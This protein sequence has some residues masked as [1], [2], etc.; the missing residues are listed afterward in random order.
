MLC[1]NVSA[2]DF[3]QTRSHQL[4]YRVHQGP[5]PEKLLALRQFLGEFGLQ[6]AG[7]ED[8]QAKDYAALLKKI[9]ERPDARI[10]FSRAA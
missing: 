8:P 5:T 7:G 6:L 3:L 1:A 2:A 9:R 4:L 10:F